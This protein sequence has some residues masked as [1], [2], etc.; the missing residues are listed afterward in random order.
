MVSPFVPSIEVMNQ[1]AKAVV[2][3]KVARTADEYFIL[4]N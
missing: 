4:N 1:W 2:A 3:A